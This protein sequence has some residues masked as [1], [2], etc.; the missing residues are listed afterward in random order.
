MPGDLRTPRKAQ[1]TS[2]KLA[3]PAAKGLRVV[4]IMLVSSPFM[5]RVENSP[6]FGVLLRED[7]VEGRRRKAPITRNNTTIL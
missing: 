1:A 5:G 7:K 3:A 4:F 6:K 2:P